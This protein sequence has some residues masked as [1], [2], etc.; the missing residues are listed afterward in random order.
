MALSDKVHQLYD[1]YR[2]TAAAI[3]A[4]AMIGF[5][6]DAQVLHGNNL[7]DGIVAPNIRDST[8]LFANGVPQLKSVKY[9]GL[10]G[11]VEYTDADWTSTYVKQINNQIPNGYKLDQNYPNPFNPETI[12]RFSIPER[13]QVNITVYDILG[14]R[15]KEIIN[16]EYA[17][18]TYETNI[19][20]E[21][22][23]NGIYF[24]NMH[25]KNISKTNK[26]L[27]LYGSQHAKTA[28]IPTENIQEN[29]QTG[30]TQNKTQ[31]LAKTTAID[32]ARIFP[33]GDHYYAPDSIVIPINGNDNFTIQGETG[34]NISFMLYDYINQGELLISDAVINVDNKQRSTNNGQADI[35]LLPGQFLPV[36][37]T[38]NDFHPGTIYT[39]TGQNDTTIKLGM[40]RMNPEPG[41]INIDDRSWKYIDS[42]GFFYKDRGSLTWNPIVD[43]NKNKIL[44]ISFMTTDSLGLHKL[45]TTDTYQKAYRD[46][47]LIF[48]NMKNDIS[49]SVL[50]PGAYFNKIYISYPDTMPTKPVI[51][52]LCYLDYTIST[53]HPIANVGT[54]Y[55]ESKSIVLGFSIMMNA[56]NPEK[57]FVAMNKE[58][59]FN[60]YNELALVDGTWFDGLNNPNEIY[61]PLWDSVK[62]FGQPADQALQR[63]TATEYLG[64]KII[65]GAL[66]MGYKGTIDKPRY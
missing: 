18:G 36:S 54:Y 28:N 49:K 55:D 34:K 41:L 63:I 13:T 29:T 7:R 61:A 40:V 32:E 15:V 21:G 10:D 4:S 2:L 3:L 14:R 56:K 16:K 19:N 5:N 52:A 48:A 8:V 66:I 37:M 44:N 6:A 53:P 30:N 65:N 33:K 62:Y 35:V 50:N 46:S 43:G 39:E 31:T 27:L 17:P 60:F 57:Y 42:T 12:Q 64:K 59:D 11:K 47:V 51:G 9:S 20:L 22:L 45:D 25:T 24:I 58:F 26:A 38:H 1:K 23:A